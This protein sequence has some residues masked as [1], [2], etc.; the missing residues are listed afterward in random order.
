MFFQFLPVIQEVALEMKILKWIPI[1]THAAMYVS[2]HGLIVADQGAWLI[3]D[4]D[5]YLDVYLG[6]AK[7]QNR[8]SIFKNDQEKSINHKTTWLRVCEL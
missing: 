1:T 4:L 6:T 3:S 2:D 5:Y 7:L 8:L